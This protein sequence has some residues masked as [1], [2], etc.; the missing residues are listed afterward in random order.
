MWITADYASIMTKFGKLSDDEKQFCL[1]DAT[2]LAVRDVL[3]NSTVN[4]EKSE[5]SNFVES[6]Q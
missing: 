6:E 1:V 3:N 5:Y 4:E 2:H